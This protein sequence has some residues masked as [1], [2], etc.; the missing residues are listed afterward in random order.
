MVGSSSGFGREAVE[1]ALSKGDKVVATLRK[2]DAIK[3]L[4]EKYPADRLVVVK[5]DVTNKQDVADAFQKAVHAFGR[6]DVVFNNAG[7]SVVTE[8]ES[9]PDDAARNLFET[10]FWGAVNVSKEAVRVFRD[11]NKPSGGRLLTMSSFVGVT[12]M[13]SAGFYTASKF[14]MWRRT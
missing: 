9:T 4:Q 12:I 8:I 10:N 6:V 5:A 14:G 3:D 2:P 13:P 11:V 7:Y 1:L